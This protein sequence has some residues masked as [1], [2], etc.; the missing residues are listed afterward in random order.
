MFLE[1][2]TLEKI[3]GHTGG[4]KKKSNG[5]QPYFLAW[6]SLPPPPP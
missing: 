6:G 2:F 5:R 1:I 3:S 4:A